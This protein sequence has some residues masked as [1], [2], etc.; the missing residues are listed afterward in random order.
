M[1]TIAELISL[2]NASSFSDV[3]IDFEARESGRTREEI[4]QE[5]EKNLETMNAAVQR[6]LTGVESV[7]GFSGRDAEK[8]DIY[9]KNNR[10]FSGIETIKAARNAIATNE[11]NAAMGVI[12]ATPTAGSA[13]VCAGV[14]NMV[15]ESRNLTHEQQIKF[16]FAA[17]AVGLSIANQASISGAQG[18][19]QAEIGS[20]S[21]MA[22]A[23][24]VEIAGGTPE[25]CGHAVALTLMNTMGLICDPV[26]G[27]VEIPCINRNA[28][29]ASLALMTADMA[30]AGIESVIP[31]DEVIQAMHQVGKKMPSCFKETA[32]G[33]LA[34]TPTGLKITEQLFGK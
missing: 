12:C 26:A 24:L 25:Q 10:S 5:M 15:K 34:T 7:T 16:L 2:A 23:G 11:V 18:G 17:G 22:S 1:L 8:L 30:L 27:L 29:G 31:A 19:C 33:G 13:G 3:I 4:W 20:A 28:M 32:E 6:G 21:A 14:I 9:L